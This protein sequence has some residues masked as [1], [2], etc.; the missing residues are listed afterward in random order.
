MNHI[1]EDQRREIAKLREQVRQLMDPIER[2]AMLS[3]GP[4]MMLSTDQ[5]V[6]VIAAMNDKL[7]ADLAEANDLRSFYIAERD[8]AVAAHDRCY[9][10]ISEARIAAAEVDGNVI[11]PTHMPYLDLSAWIRNRATQPVRADI[12]AA[13]ALLLGVLSDRTLPPGIVRRIEE[14]VGRK[15]PKA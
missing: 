5:S 6:N 14:F 13:E 1:V 11:P 9:A 3:P 15:E 12:A 7:R 8:R 4:S 2:Q 10:M